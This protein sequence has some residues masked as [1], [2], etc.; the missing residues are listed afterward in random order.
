MKRQSSKQSGFTLVE[1]AIVLVIIGLLLGGVLK[2]QELITGSKAKATVADQKAITAAMI[3]YTD[4]F[5]TIAGD[6]AGASVRFPLTACG[7]A[8]AL[9]TNGSGNGLLTGAWN[10]VPTAAPTAALNENVIAWQ[11]LRAAGFISQGD[12]TIFANPRNN[13]GGIMG[14]QQNRVYA[15]M[16]ATSLGIAFGAVPSNV[17]QAL[18]SSYDDGFANLGQW[19]NAVNGTDAAPNTVLGA[20]YVAGA[21]NNVATS[22]Q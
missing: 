19:R 3:S 5:K 18:D 8:G 4:R 2:G 12:G 17:A 22:L 15:G 9:C 14:I 11:H 20:L 16:P 13:A 1:I 7:N 10:L 21:T 6:D